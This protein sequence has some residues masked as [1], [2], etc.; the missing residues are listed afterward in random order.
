MMPLLTSIPHPS[1]SIGV[2]HNAVGTTATVKHPYELFVG[3]LSFFCEEKD[4]LDLFTRFGSVDNCRI[5]RNDSKNRSL[6]FG[7]VCM[8]T[9][10]E[11]VAA[12]NAL[13]NFMYMGRA[14]K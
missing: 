1:S 12:T 4:L 7:F 13:N 14:M 10:E 2:G 6:M 11:A 9:L 5:V 8:S 3:D